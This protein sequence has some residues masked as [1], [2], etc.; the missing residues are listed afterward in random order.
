M[1]MYLVKK[2]MMTVEYALVLDRSLLFEY[3]YINRFFHDVAQMTR[4]SHYCSW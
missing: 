3:Y 2:V 1:S 4:V